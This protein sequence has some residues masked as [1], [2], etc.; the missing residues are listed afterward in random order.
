M[1][2]EFRVVGMLEEEALCWVSPVLDSVVPSG[3]S[4]VMTFEVR[5]LRIPVSGGSLVLW[6]VVPLNA[7]PLGISDLSLVKAC[8]DN[9]GEGSWISLPAGGL[10]HP[11]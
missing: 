10:C 9:V 7:S 2:T 11:S 5:K 1:S 8:R 3:A 6:K 4:P